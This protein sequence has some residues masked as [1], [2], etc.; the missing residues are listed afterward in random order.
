MDASER[1]LLL[2][3]LVKAAGMNNAGYAAHKIYR[4]KTLRKERRG[5]RSV[6]PRCPALPQCRQHRADFAP[7][8]RDLGRRERNRE[9][10]RQSSPRR[11]ATRLSPATRCGPA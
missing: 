4:R 1:A 10:Y 8:R 6:G 2:H 11:P 3:L 7:D 9:G 5:L